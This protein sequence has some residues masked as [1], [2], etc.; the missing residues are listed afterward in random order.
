MGIVWI[1]SCEVCRIGDGSL[2]TRVQQLFEGH[3]DLLQ[4]FIQFLPQEGVYNYGM[5]YGQR[6]MNPMGVYPYAVVQEYILIPYCYFCSEYQEQQS[7]A[8][9]YIATIQERFKDSG[10]NA[11]EQFMTIVSEYQGG[12]R[13]LTEI[14]VKV[15]CL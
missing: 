15:H 2:L 11:Y 3:D 6:M 8:S 9:Q 12:I 7:F 14:V 1:Y 13:T 5:D 4:K 10:I